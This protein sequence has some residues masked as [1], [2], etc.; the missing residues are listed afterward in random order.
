MEAEGAFVDHMFVGMEI[1]AAI[2]ASL[3]AIFTSDAILLIDQHDTLLRFIRSTHRTDLYAR[4]FGTMVAHLG[5]EEA[6]FYF[7]SWN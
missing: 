6:L 3:D 5:Y 1:T 7:L 2:G 4:G